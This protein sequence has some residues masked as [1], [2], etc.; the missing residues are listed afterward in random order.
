MPN[1]IPRTTKIICQLTLLLFVL[2][3][4]GISGQSFHPDIIK[5][6]RNFK[7]FEYRA[8]IDSARLLLH[9]TAELDTV[10]MLE[11]H[12]LCAIS[13]Y[14]ITR[15][16]SS[17]SAFTALLKV[18]PA[19]ELDTRENSPKIIAFFDEIKRTYPP[20]GKTEPAVM[21][22]PLTE[23][24]P[25]APA[26]TGQTIACSIMLPGSG[27]RQ[28]GDKTKGWILSGLAVAS[29]GS[30]LYFTIETNQ[31]ENDYLNAVDKTNIAANYN[32]Y[33][34]AYRMRN[35]A[36]ILFGTVWLYTQA[37]LLFFPGMTPE[38]A[39]VDVSFIPALDDPDM[40][41]LSMQIKF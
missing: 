41:A 4:N 3:G 37:D 19:Y 5:L 32:D 35:A 21:P 20:A 31:R 2:A 29:F 6:R 27:H 16:D 18:N 28:I 15:M 34:Q 23:T 13:Y 1:P 10:D 8:V 11:L 30:A 12:R 24:I 39:T 38:Q 26:L 17:L 7:N 9:R 25:S 14:S 40:I 36:W 22:H 33:N